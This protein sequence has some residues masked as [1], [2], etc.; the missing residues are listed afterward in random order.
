MKSRIYQCFD[1]PTIIHAYDIESETA[2]LDG[3]GNDPRRSLPSPIIDLCK[4]L[5]QLLVYIRLHE[6][7]IGPIG[8]VN[9]A[10][11]RREEEALK[12]I[13]LLDEPPL[14]LL[15]TGC[16]AMTIFI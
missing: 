16:W 14:E 2:S 9:R 13:G 10:D 1:L 11:T 12:S 15:Q 4:Y 7:E 3:C 6:A 5:V 8:G